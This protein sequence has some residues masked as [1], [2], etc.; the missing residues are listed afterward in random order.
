MPIIDKID[1]HYDITDELWYSEK[2]ADEWISTC[3]CF[4][5]IYCA[6]Y[7]LLEWQT[8]WEWLELDE[9]LKW[10]VDNNGVID[11]VKFFDDEYDFKLYEDNFNKQWLKFV[12]FFYVENEEKWSENQYLYLDAFFEAFEWLDDD[13]MPYCVKPTK[14][15]YLKLEKVLEECFV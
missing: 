12:K 11:I 5:I 3:I 1:F 4:F 2:E 10:Y 14:S 15:N 13:K 8:P 9:F 6:W 7:W